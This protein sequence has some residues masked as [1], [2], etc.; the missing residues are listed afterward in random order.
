MRQG[1]RA[2]HHRAG[3]G[4]AWHGRAETS[5]RYSVLRYRRI[6]TH[7]DARIRLLLEYNYVQSRVYLRTLYL[8]LHIDDTVAGQ[9]RVK[10]KE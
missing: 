1:G 8:L 7:T 6:Q 10:S 9:G 2:G 4:W 3:Q 5:I